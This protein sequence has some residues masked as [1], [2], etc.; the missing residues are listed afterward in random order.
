M[1]RTVISINTAVPQTVQY[2]GK[3]IQTSIYKSPVSH[4]VML[5]RTNLSGDAQADLLNH[6][7]PDKAVCLYPY[8]HYAY[9]ERLWGK[10]LPYGAFGENWTA[11]GML[12]EHVHI[13]DVFRIGGALVQVSLPRQPCFKLGLRHGRPELPELVRSTGRTG[14]YFRVLE[15]GE[16]APGAPLIEVQRDRNAIT[17]A[18]VNRIKY[19]DKSNAEALKTMIALEP[20]AEA[21]K[22]S[23]RKRL[24]ELEHAGP[25]SRG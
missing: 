13:G 11:L 10:P 21:W 6:G 22:Q 24:A 16:I 23:F 17:V 18:D 15:E 25:E 12:E 14:Y 8:E 1:P 2:Q 7:G 3:D 20:L 9:W 19:S 4:P 5:R